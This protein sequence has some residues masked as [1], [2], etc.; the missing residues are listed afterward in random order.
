MV[1]LACSWCGRQY[2]V[3]ASR[4]GK[5][6]FCSKQCAGYGLF[7]GQNHPRWRGGKVVTVNGYVTVSVGNGKRAYEHRL[8]MERTLGR[9]I[10]RT[11]HV[12]HRDGDKTNNAPSNLELLDGRAHS[13]M[14]S[15]RS[16]SRPGHKARRSQIMTTAN[17]HL[18]TGRDLTCPKC[19]TTHYV[20]PSR[21][22]LRP[23]YV[24]CQQCRPG[25]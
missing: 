14:G 15:T 22:R 5:S 3:Q 23:G 20:K 19:G 1:T 21:L 9:K 16:W 12:H 7:T 4:V 25:D 24:F 13:S 2:G 8:V 18:R 11:E 10:L 17:A 6:R